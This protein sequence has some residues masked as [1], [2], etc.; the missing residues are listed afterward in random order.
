MIMIPIRIMYNY[1]YNKSKL[2]NQN[3]IQEE[4]VQIC[5]SEG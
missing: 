1:I 3:G 4:L 5:E 2:V